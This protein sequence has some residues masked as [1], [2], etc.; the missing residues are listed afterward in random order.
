MSLETRLNGSLTVSQPLVEGIYKAAGCSAELKAS[1]ITWTTAEC[2]VLSGL[3]GTDGSLTLKKDSGETLMLEIGRPVDHPK[4]TI[5][6]AKL[7]PDVPEGDKVFCYTSGNWKLRP[8]SYE[9]QCYV[10]ARDGQIH[11]V[12]PS[13]DA[14]PAAPPPSTSLGTSSS[15]K[16]RDNAAKRC[17]EIATSTNS[18]CF[19]VERDL[20]ANPSV[21]GYSL[22]DHIIEPHVSVKVFLVVADDVVGLS[23]LNVTMLGKQGLYTP[24]IL[25]STTSGEVTALVDDKP[26]SE[27][28]GYH[29]FSF[30]PRLPDSP[31]NITV[32]VE[33]GKESRTS[34]FELS[35]QKVYGGAL[36]FGLATLIG[37]AVD[38]DYDAVNVDGS[39]QREIV[40]I[41]GGKAEFEMVVA[42]TP[43][44]SG[45]R[46]YQGTTLRER[47][48]GFA[49]YIG[50]GL[51]NLTS[52]TGL[53]FFRSLHLGVEWEPVQNFS[54][55]VTMVGR[56]VTR[57]RDGYMVG[58]PVSGDVVPT[59]E[60]LTWGVGVILNVTPN[61][62]R[63]AART[64]SGL[65]SRSS[66]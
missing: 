17:R 26:P 37:P 9:G 63:F 13:A 55:A 1:K 23:K 51:V 35:V 15:Q 2:P 44:L 19:V 53:E 22:R 62:F 8:S 33:R 64:T 12:G 34:I 5:E 48:A 30:G 61:L 59:R 46:A 21:V 4:Y 45:R 50:L 29:E 54:L 32:D 11:R 52:T 66:K 38:H 27:R 7:V 24:E 49:P 57:L 25:D 28:H 18:V 47:G 3:P 65:V 31:A 39:S 43:Y 36:K 60:V 10:E 56:R 14:A 40:P 20:R 42:Y 16:A 58:S 6:Q 41:T